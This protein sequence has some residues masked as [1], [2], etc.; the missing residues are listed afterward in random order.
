MKFISSGGIMTKPKGCDD[1]TYK[2]MR[3]CWKYQASCRPRFHEIVKILLNLTS[4]D[5]EFVT[6]FQK[7][8][9]FHN[10]SIESKVSKVCYV[11][12][13][14]NFRFFLCKNIVI[15]NKF[16]FVLM[17]SLLRLRSCQSTPNS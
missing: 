9:F 17:I 7:V 12:N 13:F 3:T 16:A 5:E 11:F 14:L 6:K 2:L 4:E 10:Q 8:S 15:D 1:F